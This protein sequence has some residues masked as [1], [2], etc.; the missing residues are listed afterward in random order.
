MGLEL[1]DNALIASLYS[2]TTDPARW[3]GALDLIKQRLGL[4]SVVVQRIG[5]D[6]DMLRPLLNF[7][8][9]WSSAHAAQHDAWANSPASPRFRSDAQQKDELEIDS[10]QRS[11][12]F[13]AADRKELQEGLAG[14]G[15][16]SG[17]WIG[18]RLGPDDFVSLICHRPQGEWHDITRRE[19]DFLDT[20]SPH[21]GQISRQIASL[22]H[23]QARFALAEQFM[24]SARLAILACDDRL[25]VHWLNAAA[26]RLLQALP[27]LRLSGDRLQFRQSQAA[28]AVRDLVR[29]SAGGTCL[30]TGDLPLDG[31]LF[32]HL[33]RVGPG[34]DSWQNDLTLLALTSPRM[35]Q[36]VGAQ[37][38]K[39]FFGL[40]PAEALLTAALAQGLTV[41]EY[42]ATR[43]IAEG[44]ARMQLKSALAKA[45]VGRQTDLVRHVYTA[46]A[47]L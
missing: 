8:D 22:P 21:F 18:Y 34:P 37:A 14:C 46:L 27:Q 4:A 40:T 9:S 17:F 1:D 13:T 31:V 38:I 19:Q 35:P 30:V 5:A 15:L 7:R 3:S 41:K 25:Q 36:Q 42:A 26:E 20:L 23:A 47:Q 44:T 12:A 28:A 16:G 33:Q 29:G 43:G 6:E 32:R 24:Q 2:A 45:G 39:R 11:E 10:D